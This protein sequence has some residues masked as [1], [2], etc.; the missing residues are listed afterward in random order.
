[1]RRKESTTQGMPRFVLFAIVLVALALAVGVYLFYSPG[2]SSPVEHPRNNSSQLMV[3][4]TDAP[5][6]PA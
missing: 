1:M 2:R 4:M 3:P 6:L 5:C